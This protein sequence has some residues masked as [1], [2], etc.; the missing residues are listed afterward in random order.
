MKQQNIDQKIVKKCQNSSLKT[1]E[2]KLKI[3]KFKL[4]TDGSQQPRE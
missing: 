4:L 3:S 2:F 1:P